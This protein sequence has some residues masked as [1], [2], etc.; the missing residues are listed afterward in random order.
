MYIDTSQDVNYD[1]TK[2]GFPLPPLGIY[3]NIALKIIESI[4]GETKKQEA[5]IDIIFEIGDGE[6]PGYQFKLTYTIG[7]SNP[8]AAR[9]AREA[10][11][12]IASAITDNP[13]IH[14]SGN[15]NFDSKLYNRP[16]VGTL[17]IT[18]Q[19][20]LDS[21]GNPYKQG[22]LSKLMP[23]SGA[24]QQGNQPAGQPQQNNYQQPA[25]QN[26]QAGQP[27]NSGQPSWKRG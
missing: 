24:P 23:I 22:N 25:Q 7:S 13:N 4:D 9:I 17:T 5:K 3:P 14:K 19:A 20:N 27:Q 11:I 21:N 6:L 18:N 16:F 10:L 15:F 2:I 26:N 8:I 12:G 1:P